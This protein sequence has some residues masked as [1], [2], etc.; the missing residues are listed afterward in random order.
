MVHSLSYQDR[1]QYVESLKMLGPGK[2][3]PPEAHGP[4]Q[5]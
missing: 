4:M 2:T 1:T 5:V 3:G